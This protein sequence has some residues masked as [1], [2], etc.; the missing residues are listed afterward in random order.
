MHALCQEIARDVAR[1]QGGGAR[2]TPTSTAVPN[3]VYER[4]QELQSIASTLERKHSG[5][6]ARIAQRWS[7]VLRNEATQ[8]PGEV[9]CLNEQAPSSSQAVVVTSPHLVAKTRPSIFLQGVRLAVVAMALCGLRLIRIR[10]GEELRLP[11]ARAA[12]NRKPELLVGHSNR[13][14]TNA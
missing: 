5:A 4:L 14:N 6:Y 2:R 11:A 9:A 8:A 13:I 3:R 10:F 7:Q 1:A 12:A